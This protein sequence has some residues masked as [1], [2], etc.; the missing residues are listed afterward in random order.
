M[1]NNTLNSN[2]SI[3]LKDGRKLGYAEYGDPLGRVILYFHGFPGSRLE[4]AHFY[5]VA[6]KNHYR[7][8]GIDRPGMGLSSMDYHRTILS[9]VADVVEFADQ[10][11]IAG[12]SIFGHSGGAPFVAA[13]AYAIPERLHS[14]AVISGMAPIVNPESRRGMSRGQIIIN[15]LIQTIPGL[16]SLMM[17]LTLM[18]LKNPDRMMKQMIKQLPE[19]DQVLFQDP[20]TGKTIIGS[21]IEAFKD[22]V[23]G[24]AGEMTLLFREW[25]FDLENINCPF[26]IWQGT[27]DKQVPISHAEIYA[28]LI[29]G[30]QL[31]LVDGEGHHSLIRHYAEDILRALID[32]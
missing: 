27:L 13:C 1:M 19:V 32:C 22:G 3:T 15:C 9:W 10:L 18:M 26:T 6:V 17:R 23:A 28:K 20:E 29:P 5:D 7:V 14:A 31:K 11:G 24:P 4:A 8:I 16:A 25:G 12:F 2:L 21:T 30:A